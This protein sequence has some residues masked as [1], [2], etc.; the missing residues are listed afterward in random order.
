MAGAQYLRLAR[1]R[2]SLIDIATAR[3]FSESIATWRHNLPEVLLTDRV[4]SWSS[5]N[6]WVVIIQAMSYR[7]E[8]VFHR[9]L[10]E[11]IRKSSDEDA[12]RWCNEQLFKSIFELD[13]LMNRAIV[14][15]LVQ[16]A[17]SSL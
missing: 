3:N 4:K 1:A 7:L 2:S 15:D 6:V 17:P 13:T 12:S 16:Y 10:R 5:Q 14:N 11:Q 8:C 9:T